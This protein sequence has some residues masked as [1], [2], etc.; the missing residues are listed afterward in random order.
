MKFEKGLKIDLEFGGKTGSVSK[1]SS[2]AH[3]SE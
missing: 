2:P 1:K 3:T